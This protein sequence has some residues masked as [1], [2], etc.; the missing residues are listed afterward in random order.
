ML[1]RPPTPGHEA[2]TGLRLLVEAMKATQ[3]VPL[4][5][6]ARVPATLPC[7]VAVTV[8]FEA[9]KVL[10]HEIIV[11]RM[12]AVAESPRDTRLAGLSMREYEIAGLLAE[13]LSNQEIARHLRIALATVKV[14]VGRILRKTD[15]PNRAAVA[16]AYF[17]GRVAGER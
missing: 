6:I 17:G 3:C 12:P 11:L 7:G 5:A 15:S 1:P 2:I 8:D 9:S 14:H 4:S 10:G 16:A 13:G